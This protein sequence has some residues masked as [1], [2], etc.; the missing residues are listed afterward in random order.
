M[1]LCQMPELGK[2]IQ[3]N[4]ERERASEHLLLEMAAREKMS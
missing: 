1:C 3:E 2:Y 4:N